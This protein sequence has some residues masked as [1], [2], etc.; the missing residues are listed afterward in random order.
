MRSTEPN[1]P[2]ATITAVGDIRDRLTSVPTDWDDHDAQ[3]TAEAVLAGL[4]ARFERRDGLRRVVLYG[5]WEVDPA[6]AAA[7]TAQSAAVA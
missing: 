3:I 7:R 1:D 6:V 4:V 2:R 5:D